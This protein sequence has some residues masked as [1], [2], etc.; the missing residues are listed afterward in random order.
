[1]PVAVW[2]MHHPC[3]LCFDDFFH[4]SHVDGDFPIHSEPFC[5]W[6]SGDI[7]FGLHNDSFVALPGG[8]GH[9]SNAVLS[10]KIGTDEK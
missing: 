8:N 7:V 3:F 5:L 4:L 2:K 9:C 10:N 1:M 6:G